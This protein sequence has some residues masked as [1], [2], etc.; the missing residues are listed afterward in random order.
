MLVEDARGSPADAGVG[1]AQRGYQQSA[2]VGGCV[3]AAGE[4]HAHGVGGAGLDHLCLVAQGLHQD[5][6]RSRISHVSQRAG[7]G[8][9]GQRLIALDQHFADLLEDG[10]RRQV[11]KLIELGEQQGQVVLGQ[12]GGRS[13]EAGV[14]VLGFGG[15][16]VEGGEG[17]HGKLRGAEGR[18]EALVD[19]VAFPTA[20]LPLRGHH[21]FYCEGQVLI[22]FRTAA[23]HGYGEHGVIGDEVRGLGFLVEGVWPAALRGFVFV[24]LG[25]EPGRF[26]TGIWRGRWSTSA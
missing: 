2:A 22:G 20:F 11:P 6:Q 16:R 5:G 25:N 12:L 23:G 18:V 19:G 10:L 24:E 4:D 13:R 8:F 26:A 3:L 21:G 15:S 17:H 7:R 14:P 9:A 1:R